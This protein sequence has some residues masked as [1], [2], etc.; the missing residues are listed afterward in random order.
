MSTD[1]T[2]APFLETRAK[3]KWQRFGVRRRAGV[4]TPLFSIYSKDSA[5]IGEFPDLDLLADWTASCGMSIIQLLPMNDVGSNFRPYDADSTFALEPMYLR[6]DALRGADPAPFKKDIAKLK[7]AFPCGMLK[8][9]YGV[10]AAK[11]RLLRRMFES[12]DRGAEFGAYVAAKSFWLE[13][14]AIYRVIKD[15]HGNKAWEEWPAELRSRDAKT[16]GEFVRAHRTEIGF[17]QWLQWQ[18]ALQFAAAKSYAASKGV[19][20]LGD[21][22]FLVSRDSADVWAHQNYF[23]LELLAGAPPDA[24]FAAGQRWGMPPYR[25]EAIAADG[26]R[27]LIEKVKTAEEFY[28]LFRIDHVVGVF[29][30][31]TIRADEPVETQGLRGVFDPADES[32]WEE[33]GR[34]ILG[35]MLD[36]SRMLPCAE[37]LGV[38]PPCS[39]KVLGEFGIP[40]IDVERWTRDWGNTYDFKSPH[41]WRKGAIAVISTHDTTPLGVWWLY[42]CGTIDEDLFRR[43]LADRGIP[44][45]LMKDKLFDLKN[46]AH[47]RLRWKSDLRSPHDVLAVLGLREEE[48][49]DFIDFFLAASDE[50]QKFLKFLGLA[51]A[52]PERMNPDFAEAIFKRTSETSPIFAVQLLQDWLAL[53]ASFEPDRWDYRINFP[54][55]A[56]DKNWTLALPYSLE[57]MKRLKANKTIRRIHAE[58]DRI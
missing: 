28:D 1:L 33:Q 58:T 9:D 30:L 10:K 5:G 26:Y 31:W 32:Q 54:G 44:F 21:L 36:H 11:L 42:E 3:D 15:H 41:D 45:D 20:F 18:S 51:G 43:R 2:Y 16:L 47:G 6:L 4:A 24:F 7:Q 37:D 40:G 49:R 22:P 17:Y 34:R 53:D 55:T 13:D 38:V 52:P 8:V 25:W 19:F 50:K 39:Y 35:V 23:K 57:K 27:Y 46:S 12:A 48:A 29:R 56:D 14:W